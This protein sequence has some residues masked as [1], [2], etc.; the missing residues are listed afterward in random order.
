MIKLF[1]TVAVLGSVGSFAGLAMAQG[2]QGEALGNDVSSLLAKLEAQ[3]THR[4]RTMPPDPRDD[5]VSK[6]NKLRSDA[7][8]GSGQGGA[9]DSSSQTP[10]VGP[11]NGG[12]PGNGLGPGN[13]GGPGNGIGPGSGGGQ[14]KGRR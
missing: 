5:C 2:K 6:L 4:R 10:G 12:G 9:P 14:G 13:G 1:L 7:Q 8:I 3:C 11:G